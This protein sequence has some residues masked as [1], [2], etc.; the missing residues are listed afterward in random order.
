MTYILEQ[1][2]ERFFDIQDLLMPKHKNLTIKLYSYL[3][4]SLAQKFSGVDCQI[5]S[6]VKQRNYGCGN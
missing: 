1:R 2:E 3:N 5:I 6:A 4:C